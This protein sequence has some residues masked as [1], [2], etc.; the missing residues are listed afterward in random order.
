M[1][2]SNQSSRSLV[3]H[4]QGFSQSLDYQ[5]NPCPVS[6]GHVYRSVG[7]KKNKKQKTGNGMRK[8]ER[9]GREVKATCSPS[10]SLWTTCSLTMGTTTERAWDLLY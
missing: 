8:D 1:I 7:K 6:G 9:L 3:I 5:G 2:I 4:R 10:P